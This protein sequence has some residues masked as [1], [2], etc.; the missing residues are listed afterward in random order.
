MTRLE[1]CNIAIKSNILHEI[2]I[3]FHLA[4]LIFHLLFLLK[5]D[6]NLTKKFYYLEINYRRL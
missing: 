6:E 2:N 4:L 3:N 1:Y 5:I